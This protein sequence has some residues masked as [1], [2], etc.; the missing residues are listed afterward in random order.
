[1]NTPLIPQILE[2]KLIWAHTMDGSC[3]LKSACHLIMQKILNLDHLAMND[4]WQL[5][6][7]LKI[8]PRVKMTLWR[9]C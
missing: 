8:P 5:L 2:D 1:M 3:L 9:A 6:W 4:E 7:N